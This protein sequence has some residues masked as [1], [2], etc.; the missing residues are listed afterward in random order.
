MKDPLPPLPIA[1]LLV[2]V[3]ISTPP[4]SSSIFTEAPGLPRYD[5]RIVEVVFLFQVSPP[6]G[7]LTVILWE[8]VAVTVRAAVMV[9]AHAPVPEQ[10]PPHPV[11]NEP[12]SGACERFTTVP[13]LYVAEQV[14]PQLIPAGE[15]VTVPPPVPEFVVVRLYVLMAKLAVTVQSS[16]IGPVV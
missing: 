15:L 9:T 7:T 2:M 10:P 5:Q 8:N 4:L 16:V 14:E 13:W 6:L 3:L 1:V 12:A 11:K